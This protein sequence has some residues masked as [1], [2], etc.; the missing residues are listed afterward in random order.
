MARKR[1]TPLRVRKRSLP[2]DHEALAAYIVENLE[3]DLTERSDWN[4]LRIQ[5][6]AKMRGWREPKTFPWDDASNAHIP[7][8][9]TESLRTQDTMHN[10]VLANHPVVESMAVQHV[11][12]GKQGK[13][14]S[15]IDYQVFTEQPGE[16]IVATLIQQ[17]VEDGVFLAYVPWVRYDETVKDVR[18][19]PAIPPDSSIADGVKTAI[20]QIYETVI[21]MEPLDEE[22]FR[23]DATILE[24]GVERDL[25]IEAYI[26]EVDAR[27]EL[28]IQK[29]SRVY[30]GPVIIPKSIDEWVAPARSGNVQPP[31][32]S[33]PDGAAHVCLLDYPQLD[34]IRRLKQQGHYDLCT[35]EDL[36]EMEASASQDPEQGEQNAGQKILKDAFEGVAPSQHRD[37]PE[38]ASG[39][40]KLTR[41]LAFLG[42]DTNRDGLQ[43]QIVVTMIKETRT[44]LRVRHLTES[45]PSDPPF[46]P[47]ASAGY[48]PVSGRLYAISLIELLE[49]IHDLLK[50][51]FDKMDD[52]ATLKNL[53]WFAYKPTSGLAP[54]AISIAPGEGVPMNDPKN[55]IAVPPFGSNGEAYGMNMI[56]LLNQFAE[57]ASMQGDIQFGRVPQGKS[58]ALRTAAGMKSLL[59]RGDARPERILRRFFSGFK[60]VYRIIHELNQRFLPKKKEFRLMEP[61]LQGNSVYDNVAD[62]EAISGRMQFMFKAGMFNSNKEVATQILQTLMQILINPLMLQMGVVTAKEIHTL[63][64]DFIKL[65]QQDPAR[66]LN[67]PQPGPPTMQATAE[68]AVSLLL[69]GR[70]PNGTTPAEGP[71][72]HRQKI[73][74]FMQ[75]PDF[76]DLDPFT[77]ALFRVYISQLQQQ[78]QQ[79]QQ[80][81]Q[82]MQAAQQFQQSAGGGG[83]PGPQGQ[84]G[85]PNTG[86]GGNPPL[87]PNELLD[88]SLPGAR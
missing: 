84:G 88:E 44:I 5:R 48:L 6:Y 46:R 39:T 30:D 24:E 4:E 86:A 87:G 31:S 42:W 23:W 43:E 66:Y 57:R 68:E 10:A 62:L 19:F 71:Q 28:V 37:Q 56:A 58:S 78:A 35:D 9:I 20:R 32:P 15:L 65:V 40:G 3:Q 55:D 72:V 59:A 80:Q 1:K 45:Y 49:S 50:T 83:T 54:Q 41:I 79:A 25:H 47:L 70:M 77:Q 12:Q 11:N 73:Q 27:V 75:R 13:I 81:Q 36:E 67:A 76:E 64:T 38:E 21:G 61:D 69:A 16:E 85:A 8:L 52:A 18:I 33:N 34:E 51:T 60:D 82:L 53:P 29:A 22:G 26:Q 14:D 2:L 7:F 63:L 17:Y 74:Q